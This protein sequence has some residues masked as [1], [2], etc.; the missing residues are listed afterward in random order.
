LKVIVFSSKII[1]WISM[2]QL[3]LAQKPVAYRVTPWLLAVDVTP[4]TGVWKALHL[5]FVKNYVGKL[6]L[7]IIIQT[8]TL[9]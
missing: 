1:G 7:C 6:K 9:R 2:F 5:G 4:F 3:F 8:G